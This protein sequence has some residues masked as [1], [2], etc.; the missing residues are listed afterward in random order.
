MN[1]EGIPKKNVQPKT[2]IKTGKTNQEICHMEEM[3]RMERN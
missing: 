1:K 2:T 3:K